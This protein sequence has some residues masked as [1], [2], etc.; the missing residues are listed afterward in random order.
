MTITIADWIS[1]GQTIGVPSI[2]CAAAF[3]F[4]YKKEIWSQR[5]R[6]EYMTREVDADD[7]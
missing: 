4:I 6:K 5:E 7:R 3:F 1:I 2:V